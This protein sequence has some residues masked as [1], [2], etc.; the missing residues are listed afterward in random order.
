MHK[1]WE[2]LF[3]E[4]TGMGVAL[5]T[6][7]YHK[8]YKE[9]YACIK[10]TESWSQ[11]QL[12]RY[13]W[14]Q[15]LL[16]LQHAYDHVPYYKKLFKSQNITPQDIQTLQDFQKLP[17]LTKELVQ[18]HAR[19]LK[20]TNYP[21]YAFEETNTGGSTGFLLRFPVEKGV[22]YAKHLAYI[23]ALLERGGC[24]TM[25]PSVQLIGR[26]KPWEYRLLP[27]TLL[28][29]SY[30]M[31]ERNLP[32]YL[33]KIK[34]L[35]PRYFL[36]YPSAITLLAQY[37]KQQ[38]FE[39]HGLKAIFCF[40]ET[41]YEWQREFL[42]TFFHCQV[43]GQYGQREQCVFAGTCEKSTY[44]HIFAD[45][46]FAELIDR[47]GQPVTQDG[48]SGEI[49]GT[50][51]HTGIF[52][53]IRYKTGDIAIYSS[54]R[55]ECGR[56][57]LL[58]QTIE[59][60]VQDFMVSKSKRLVPLM[61]VLQLIARS[62]PNMKEYQLYQDRE[63]ELVLHVVKKEGFSDEDVRS[64]KEN[65]QNR[66]KDEFSLSLVYLDSIPRTSRGKYQF[67]VQKLPVEHR[68]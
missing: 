37:M 9:T 43:H 42:E 52:P 27:R 36:G 53:F 61:G 16:L 65:V 6:I 22:W 13:Q 67:L 24:Q 40:G 7:F 19:E 58:F 28:L 14:E 60:R 21:A 64:I 49:V 68:S 4:E 20:A 57:T 15:L 54:H 18:K 8:S 50:G 29:S 3:N 32:V 33:R 59:G 41:L 34:K 48:V 25:D 39:L 44:Y 55:C 5:T 31:T 63:G 23:T 10:Q 35:K 45:Y 17:F 26:E 1:L 51:F 38:S 56:R 66:L 47:D 11:E 2:R 30:Q 62:S 12:H 46:G